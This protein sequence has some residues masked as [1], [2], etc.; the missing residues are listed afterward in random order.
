MYASAIAGIAFDCG[1]LHVTHALEHAMSALNA[2]ITHGEGL[3]ILLPA[4]LREIY[5][6]APEILAELLAPLAPGLV[7][8]PG[9]AEIAAGIVKE[10]L[11]AVGQATSL[12]AYFTGA[13]VPALTR[14][15][16]K[17]PSS[18]QFLSAAPVRV[19]ENVVQRIFQRS[20]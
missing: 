4:V 2:A 13:D 14:M 15:A 6:A 1:A 11:G 10:W 17:S 8:L 3:G 20:L 19:D 5:P 16:L 9:E 12:A 7:G 18:K